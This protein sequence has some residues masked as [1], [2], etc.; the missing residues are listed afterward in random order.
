[1]PTLYLEPLGQ[2]RLYTEQWKIVSYLPLQELTQQEAHIEEGIR[3]MRQ[4]DFGGQHNRTTYQLERCLLQAKRD[5]ERLFSSVGYEFALSNRKRRGVFNFIGDISKTLFGT[6]SD[7]DAKYYDREIDLVHKDN[8]R[9]VELFK[10]Q[11][12]ILKVVLERNDKLIEDYRN[13][14]STISRHINRIESAEKTNLL[15][16][17]ILE[18]GVIL[19]LEILS[20]RRNIDITNQAILDGRQGNISPNII[21]PQVFLDIV[22]KLKAEKGT[23]RLPKVTVAE[24]YYEYLQICNI[25]IGIINRNLVSVVKIPILETHLYMQYKVHSIPS[26]QPDGTIIRLEAPQDYVITNVERTHMSPSS[27]FF[28][29]NCKKLNNVYYCKRLEPKYRITKEKNCLGRWLR[30]IFDNNTKICTPF[31]GIMQYSLYLP[32]QTGTDWIIIPNKNEQIQMLCGQTSNFVTLTRPSIIHLEPNCIASTDFV[33]LEPIHMSN[34]IVTEFR[35]DLPNYNFSLVHESYQKMLNTVNLE[36]LNIPKIGRLDSQILGKRL[37]DLVKEAETISKHQ[38]TEHYIETA[39]RFGTYLAYGL[40]TTFILY[41][42]YKIR[43]IRLIKGCIS[44]I[45]RPCIHNTYNNHMHG[46]RNQII[47]NTAEVATRHENIPIT[48][49]NSPPEIELTDI[50][51]MLTNPTRTRS[52]PANIRRNEDIA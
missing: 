8:Q 16:E 52:K 31:V 50:K 3:N 22:Q 41:V 13:K 1:M 6:M 36:E 14:I 15:F 45:T 39:T 28:L 2:L 9:N 17:T 20:Y 25:E 43:L 11:T 10:N 32:L 19:E 26:V 7:E 5:R 23:N 40:L 18:L 37:E 49:I 29:D 34:K 38:R 21:D 48:R 24:H 12:Q 30:E 33:I 46:N 51:R 27:S 44:T 42:S 47:N 35:L 4:L